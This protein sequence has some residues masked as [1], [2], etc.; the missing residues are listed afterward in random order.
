MGFRPPG[1]R[2]EATA[3]T[4]LS[5]CRVCKG[6]SRDRLFLRT[7]FLYTIFLYTIFLPPTIFLLLLPSPLRFPTEHGSSRA[8]RTTPTPRRKDILSENTRSVSTTAARAGRT[9]RR[10]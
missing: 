3:S 10:K 7:I 9:T 1:P 5:R 2:E 8:S 4:R 6:S